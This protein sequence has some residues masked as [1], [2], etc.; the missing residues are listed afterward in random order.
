[1]SSLS[2]SLCHSFFHMLEKHLASMCSFYVSQNE[3]LLHWNPPSPQNVKVQWHFFMKNHCMLL[4]H[5]CTMLHT[6]QRT[7]ET[8]QISS[9]ILTHERKANKILDA[10]EHVSPQIF[11][12]TIEMTVLQ[13]KEDKAIH[14][15]PIITISGDQEKVLSGTLNTRHMPHTRRHMTKYI[16]KV[17]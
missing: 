1:M 11:I 9:G 6:N 12:C 4:F 15:N 17:T 10:S 7:I 8:S 14:R 5:S 3:F 13:Y 16:R 2:Q